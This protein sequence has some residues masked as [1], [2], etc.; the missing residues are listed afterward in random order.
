MIVLAAFALTGCLV[1]GAGSDRIT[2][3]DLAPVFPGVASG[4]PDTPVALAP[5]PGV[6]RVFRAPELRQFA[7]RFN[8]AP[9]EGL[10]EVC[11]ERPVAVPDPAALLDE[12]RR[13]L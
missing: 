5:A 1:V 8:T 6:Q 12:M 13:Q 9:V 3:H 7:A 11:F 10:N 4:L 2:V